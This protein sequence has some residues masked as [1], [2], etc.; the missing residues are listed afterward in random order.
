MR[1]VVPIVL[2][3]ACVVGAVIVSVA[4]AGTANRG[5]SQQAAHT[6]VTP[7]LPG[8]INIVR[9]QRLGASQDCHGTH[10]A[11]G[12][13]PRFT[14][15]AS[16]SQY[17]GTLT[18][19]FRYRAHGLNGTTFAVSPF[20]VTPFAPRPP[21]Q[22]AL[23]P[24]ERPLLPTASRSST[25]TIISQASPLYGRHE[26]RLGMQASM[27]GPCL[28]PAT[29]DLATSALRLTQVVYSVHVWTS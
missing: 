7:T 26:Y 2:T 14:L 12:R 1:R 10:V 13:I 6:S 18:V 28:D 24:T 17:R 22:P 19:S 11:A 27:A 3:I 15:P 16:A 20:M 25:T 5:P 4:L 21:S 8:S 23:L 9:Y 29:G